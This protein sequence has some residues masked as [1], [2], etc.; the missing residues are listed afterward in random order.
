MSYFEVNKLKENIIT[1]YD[2]KENS[3]LLAV[4]ENIFDLENILK[5]KLSKVV[6]QENF[7]NLTDK[8][9]YILIKDKIDYLENAKELLNY[10]GTIILLMNNRF[11]IRFFAGDK[12]K[13]EK[14]FSSIY[15]NQSEL[16][17]KR[18]IKDKLENLGF[19]NYKFY[20]PLPSY[21]IPNVI[22][23]DDYLPK[24]TNTKL[25][26]N[27]LYE[28]KVNLIFDES[29]ALKELT[30]S[31]EFDF[32][33]NSYFIEIN[34][35]NKVKFA[36]FNNTRKDEYC[37]VTKMYDDVVVKGQL[38]E[39]SKTHIE[40][41]K[42]YIEDLKKHNIKIVD[43]AKE[44]TIV[45]KYMSE[46]TLYQKIVEN[47]ENNNLEEAFETIKKWYNFLAEKFENDR[48]EE[49][50]ENIN[51]SG[52]QDLSIVKNVYIDLTFENT[53][54]A[55]NEFE[56]FDQEWCIEK[57]PLE[58]ILYRAIRNL[59]TYNCEIENIL[60]Q[61]KIIEKFNLGKYLQ[62]FEKIENFIQEKF[63]NKDKFEYYEKFK[64]IIPDFDMINS[65]YSKNNKLADYALEMETLKEEDKK[66]EEYI[67]E[68]VKQ[69]GDYNLLKDEN[70][71]KTKY[72]AE[73]TEQLGEV[74]LVKEEN[75][76]K[77]EYIN[78]LTKSLGELNLLREENAKKTEYINELTNQLGELNLLKEED[79]KK[80][81]YIE[82][83]TKSL[84][85]LNLYKE[86]NLKKEKYI[87]EL[88]NQLNER[89]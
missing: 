50:N 19:S 30:K 43:E 18:E 54:Y 5:S 7:D 89:K 48:V 24:Y 65:L 1:W 46:K 28:E 23:S 59:Y 17:S 76:K 12:Y 61:R 53:F 74:N 70:A 56:F 86:E 8:F 9:D 63:M 34:P 66:K 49:I 26:Y 83:L 11:G 52:I 55:N 32:F 21:D 37:L 87:E 3:K 20:Y 29:K 77:T 42:K 72:I 73:L 82:E 47:I 57:L 10:D 33:A 38:S 4:G 35:K 88:K 36:S 14:I 71:K 16:L 75:L 15:E 69:L 51:G 44:N 85:E 6:L 84:G 80:S 68:L 79:S 25:N 78:E 13:N 45:S 62:I 58:F 40:N 81:A 64:K 60:P 67:S 31:G 39:K 41:M 2:F 22:F 27:N